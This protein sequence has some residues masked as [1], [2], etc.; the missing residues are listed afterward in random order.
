M[1]QKFSAVFAS[2]LIPL[3]E[4]IRKETR[5]PEHSEGSPD[6]MEMARKARHD[7][8]LL[9]YIYCAIPTKAGIHLLNVEFNRPD[10]VFHESLQVF[11]SQYIK[12]R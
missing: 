2:T 10:F 8:F 5:H 6:V 3:G 4:N 11:Y 1:G 12:L 9:K 7:V